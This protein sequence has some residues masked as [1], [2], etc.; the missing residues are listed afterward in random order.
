VQRQLLQ[1]T[2]RSCWEG[3]EHLQPFREAIDR[4]DIGRAL[5]GALTG[6]LPLR[7]GLRRHACCRVV[8]RQPFRLDGGD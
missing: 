4:L 3:L 2:L 6:P 5:D 8:L 7:H 1:G